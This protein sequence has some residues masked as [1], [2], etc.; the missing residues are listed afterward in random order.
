MGRFVTLRRRD[1]TGA[2]KV[3]MDFGSPEVVPAGFF[4]AAGARR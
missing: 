4:E 1:A 3:A 2:W